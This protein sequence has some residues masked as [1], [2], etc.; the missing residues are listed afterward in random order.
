MVGAGGMARR[1]SR[2]RKW[3]PRTSQSSRYIPQTRLKRSGFKM[4]RSIFLTRIL[5]HCAQRDTL[6][7]YNFEKPAHPPASRKALPGCDPERRPVV[8][9][10][11]NLSGHNIP[12]PAESKPMQEAAQRPSALGMVAAGHFSAERRRVATQV[13]RSG[14][15]SAAQ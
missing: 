7:I 12:S 11:P 2:A 13:Q 14:E 10:S 3:G 1:V 9:T 5:E 4:K 6:A 15:R 8:S